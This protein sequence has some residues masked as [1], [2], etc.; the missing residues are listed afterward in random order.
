MWFGTQDGLNK[1]DGYKF[2]VYRNNKEDMNSLSNNMITCLCEDRNSDLWIGTA[3]G[4]LNKYDRDN[5]K[6]ISYIYDENNPDSISSNIVRSVFEDSDGI[7]WIGT[8]Y[9]GLNKFDRE[10]NVFVRYNQIEGNTDGI[11][12]RSIRQI[13]EDSAKNLWLATWN[14]GVV[15]FD[16][17]KNRF[18]SYKCKN[19]IVNSNRI[20]SIFIDSRKNLWA[21]TNEGLQNINMET[22]EITEYKYSENSPDGINSNFP[23]VILED[24]TGTFWVATKDGGLN[25]FNYYTGKFTYYLNDKSDTKSIKSNS[26]YSLFEDNSGIIWIGTNGEGLCYFNVKKKSFPHYNNFQDDEGNSLGNKISCFCSENE[27]TFWIGTMD[28]GLLKYEISEQK[29]TCYKNSEDDI[30]SL[31]DDRVSALYYDG[32]NN[33]WIGTYGGGLNKLDLKE[34]KFKGFKR[35]ADGSINSVSSNAVSSIISDK[36]GNLWL[37]TGDRGINKLDPDKEIFTYFLH[38]KDNENSISSDRIRTLLFDKEGNIWIGLDVGGL[39]KFDPSKDSFT[40]FNKSQSYKS[41]F[42]NN[43]I[44]YLLEDSS[45]NIWIGTSGGGLFYYDRNKNEFFNYQEKDGLPNNFIN[46]ILE[47]DNGCIW[48]ST[49]NGISRFDPVNNNFKNYDIRDGLQSNEFNHLSALKLK[50]GSLVFGGINGFNVFHPDDLK[51]NEHI[52]QIE[53]TDF[54]IFNKRV[55]IGEGDSPLK[56][57]ISETGELVLSYSDSVFSFEFA[58]LDFNIPGKNQYAYKMEGF[59]KDWVYSGNRRFVTYTNLNPGEYIFRVKGSNNDGIWNEEGKSIKLTITPPF[60][61]TIWFKSLS[62]ITIAGLIRNRY[63]NKINEVNKEK[64]AQED[65]TK[66][67]IDTQE[68]DRKRIAGELHDSIGSDLLITKNKLQLS[69]KNNEDKESIVKDINEVTEILSSTINEVREISYNLHPYQIERLGLTKAIQSIIDRTAK[70]TALKF[71]SNVDILDKIL[72]P[73]TEISLFRIIQECI[74]NIVKH[75]SAEEVI[76]NIKKGKDAV[77]IFISD[78]G[79]GFSMETVKANSDKHGFGLKGMK[80]R[81]K[82]FN[83]KLEMTSSPGIG[84]DINITI[85]L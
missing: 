10:K 55:P 8:T 51:E 85:P 16:R 77:S 30:N 41:T 20:N 82:L 50:N 44:T 9:G 11:N 46:A 18:I 34:Q 81:V 64:K 76:V 70:S 31:N 13:T 60:W 1:Y 23:S 57:A 78:N 25:K 74:N 4:G 67:L 75:S 33:L 6:F 15:K 59:D 36:D 66:R 79:K 42:K 12:I 73:E 83:G 40:N 5:D 14:E 47:D 39:N 56:K 63:V 84:T 48:I 32:K 17:G 61:K 19:N 62:V 52:P 43:S 37:G 54:Q 7:L 28:S 35:S 2:T 72:K 49:N 53:I 68:G 80:E 24:S 26:V 21:C 65:F 29:F 45:R 22:G 27:N 58:A 38:E 69:L 71:V 3:T